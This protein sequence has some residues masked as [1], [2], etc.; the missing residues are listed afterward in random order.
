MYTAHRVVIFPIARLSCSFSLMR[1]SHDFCSETLA[2]E[3]DNVQ[4]MHLQQLLLWID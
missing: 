4:S 2:G 1:L 3:R